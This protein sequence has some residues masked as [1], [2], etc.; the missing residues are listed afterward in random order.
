[1]LAGAAEQ[2]P[3]DAG[4]QRADEVEQAPPLAQPRLDRGPVQ[5]GE[6]GSL[7]RV[8]VGRHADQHV[9][10]HGYDPIHTELDRRFVELFFAWGPHFYEELDAVEP[11]EELR[12]IEAG[13]IEAIGFRF[14]GER[15][16]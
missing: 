2:G 1:M 13:E 12:L 16:P 11:A 6:E 7:D 9:A 14:V 3:A 4:D 5:L 10:I 8:H 15:R